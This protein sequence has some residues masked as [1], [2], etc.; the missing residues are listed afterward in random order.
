MPGSIIALPMHSRK[1]AIYVAHTGDLQ[2]QGVRYQLLIWSSYGRA[3]VDASAILR[4]LAC[5]VARRRGVFEWR[6]LLDGG[7]VVI[8]WPKC[9]GASLVML[10]W[11]RWAARGASAGG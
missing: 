11:S 7:H 8:W 9:A 10:R 4:G 3:H 1:Q 2:W 5:A 6:M